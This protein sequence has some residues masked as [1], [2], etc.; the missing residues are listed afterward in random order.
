VDILGP[1]Y[2][3]VKPRRNP[4]EF[5]GGRVRVPSG[6]GLGVAVDASELDALASAESPRSA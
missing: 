3:T 5:H 4:V 6:A 2:Y 1:L